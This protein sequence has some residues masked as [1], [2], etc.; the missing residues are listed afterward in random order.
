MEDTFIISPNDKGLII[1]LKEEANII[2]RNYIG[3]DRYEYRKSQFETAIRLARVLEDSEPSY[4]EDINNPIDYIS[5]IINGLPLSEITFNNNEFYDFQ[6]HGVYCNKRYGAFY[7]HN[8]T[9]KDVYNNFAYNCIVTKCY[10]HNI[11]SQMDNNYTKPL[12]GNRTLY[13]SKG[14]IVTGEFIGECKFKDYII[15]KGCYDVEKYNFNINVYA[16]SDY[17]TTIFIV[18]SR[19]PILRELSKIY[20]FEILKN[21]DV[22]NK[23]YNIRKYAKIV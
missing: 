15:E 2:M 12:V 7:K 9:S 1:R 5:K 11:L 23:K 18:D 16:I 13:L 6:S 8:L 22:A 20:D 17:N 10:N 21:E 4:D 3:G 19:N 14:G